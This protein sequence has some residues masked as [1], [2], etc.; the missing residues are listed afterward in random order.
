MKTFLRINSGKYTV[1]LTH[2]M[3]HAIS[4]FLKPQ[5]C[6]FCGLLINTERKIGFR[7]TIKS[8]HLTGINLSGIRNL[9]ISE[10]KTFP[11][12]MFLKFIFKT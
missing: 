12:K 3:T 6:I 5:G 7:I 11:A 10:M 8:F 9:E 1:M 2:P 4:V